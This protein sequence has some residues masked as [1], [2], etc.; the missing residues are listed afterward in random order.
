MVIG[1]GRLLQPA[2]YALVLEKLFPG[3]E[4]KEGRLYYSSFT[5]NFSSVTVPLDRVTR[6]SV[7]AVATTLGDAIRQGFLP[8]APDEGECTWCDYL[9]VC[10]SSAE[11]RAGRKPRDRIASLI[12]LREMP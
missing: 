10:G 5:G 3:T 12:R 1:G 4:V 7:K 11:L 9:P 2:L 8:A 6:D